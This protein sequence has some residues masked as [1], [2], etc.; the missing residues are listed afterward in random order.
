M[1]RRRRR[2]R[3][4][5]GDGQAPLRATSYRRARSDVARLINEVIVVRYLVARA[6]AFAA[7]AI[8]S[9]TVR[10]CDTYTA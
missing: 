5:G 2:N 10:G 9:A 3:L 4:A 1:L 8:R 7:L 6:T